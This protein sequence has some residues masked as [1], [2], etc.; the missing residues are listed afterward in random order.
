[1]RLLNIIATCGL[2]LGCLRLPAAPAEQIRIVV[3]GDSTTAPRKNLI[4]YGALLEADLNQHHGGSI[5]VINAGVG[6]NTTEKAAARFQRDVLAQ[7]PA[8]VVI[9]FGI[10]DSTVD[11]WKKPPAAASRVPVAQYRHNLRSFVT[12]LQERKVPVILMTPNPLAWTEGLKAKYGHAPYRP[13]DPDGFNATLSAY[14]EAVREIA[15]ESGVLLIDVDHA[16]R[17]FAKTSATPLLLDGM[18]PNQEGHALVA[19]LL[20]REIGR[21]SLVVAPNH[22]ST[23]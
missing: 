7:N 6:G 17:D 14:A 21:H 8:L 16:H 20:A 12:A 18:H 4:E 11:V 22:S 13:E 3:F 1:M 19:R 15:R 23:P 2:L 10:N 5:R 9:Q